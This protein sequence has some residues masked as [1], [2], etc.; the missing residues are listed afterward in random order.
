[1]SRA[2]CSAGAAMKPATVRARAGL[3]PLT[4]ADRGAGEVRAPREPGTVVPAGEAPDMRVGV[5]RGHAGC[6]S[7]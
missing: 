7:G 6:R 2:I 1:M 5:A 4:H 3:S